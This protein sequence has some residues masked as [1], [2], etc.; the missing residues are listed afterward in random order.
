MN[1]RSLSKRPVNIFNLAWPNFHRMSY[2]GVVKLYRYHES[3]RNFIAV[4]KKS[5][6]L[7]FPDKTFDHEVIFLFTKHH[8]L[9]T[10]SDQK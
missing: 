7:A 2:S 9:F 5:V 1:G 8:N 4:T 3:K 10:R 6:N